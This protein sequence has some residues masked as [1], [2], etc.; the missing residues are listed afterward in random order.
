MSAGGASGTDVQLKRAFC[1]EAVVTVRD[2][3][4]SIR[5]I[6]NFLVLQGFPAK[7]GFC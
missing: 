2:G 5:A 1:L 3:R 6:L 7:E 4:D